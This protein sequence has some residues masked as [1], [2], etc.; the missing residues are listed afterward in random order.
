MQELMANSVKLGAG[1]SAAVG[2]QGVGQGANLTADFVSY[3]KSKG[4]FLG[5]N[6]EGSVLDVRDTLNRAY[7]GSDIKPAEITQ[8][9]GTVNA[10]ADALR[11]AVAAVAG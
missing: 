3:A 6:V 8:K 7:Y 2:A 11:K 4:A 1:V 9:H 10:G 5:M